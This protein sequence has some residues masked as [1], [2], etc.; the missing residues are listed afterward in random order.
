MSQPQGSLVLVVGPSGVGKD[1]L[2]AGAKAALG[3]DGRFVFV[4]RVITREAHAELEDHDSLDVPTFLAMEAAGRF[5]LS[6]GAHG[7][8]YGLPGSVN[9]D[10]A[11]GNVVI[12]NGSRQV[13]AEARDK[14]PTC[15]VILITAEI[16]LRA[17][18][19]SQRGRE[20]Q[21]EVAARLAREGAA[22]PASITPIVIDNS[23]TLADGIDSLVKALRQIAEQ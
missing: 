16:S 12:A 19:L 22:V 7:L 2:M 5:A 14:Y 6:W 17:Q 1:T 9:D 21:E 11:R 20:T 15:S 13:L 4:R 3:D 8:H 23:G 18:R 10:I